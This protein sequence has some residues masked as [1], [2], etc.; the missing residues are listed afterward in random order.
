MGKTVPITRRAFPFKTERR[1][2]C[3]RAGVLG[4]KFSKSQESDQMTIL[5][6]IFVLLHRIRF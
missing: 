6:P 3:E 1:M 2:A 5:E 4:P